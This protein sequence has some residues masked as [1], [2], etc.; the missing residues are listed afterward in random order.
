MN[1]AGADGCFY[2]LDNNWHYLRNWH[3]LKQMQT[4]A[5]LPAQLCDHCPDYRQ[6][7][8]PQSEAIIARTVA[9]QIKLGWSQTQ[10]AQRIATIRQV[11]SR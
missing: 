4:A 11:L 10:L 3:H 7:A 6:V 9:M 5:R 8:V 2:Y 1:S